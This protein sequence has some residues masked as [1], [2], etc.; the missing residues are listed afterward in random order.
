MNETSDSA[1]LD[2]V[3]E[4]CLFDADDSAEFVGGEFAAVDDPVECS[5]CDA[6][7]LGGLGA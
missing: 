7:L 3:V 2:V 6:Q 4:V 5:Q 1:A